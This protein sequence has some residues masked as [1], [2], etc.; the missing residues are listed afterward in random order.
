MN[1]MPL[2]MFLE[3][4]FYSWKHRP[5]LHSHFTFGYVAQVH[6]SKNCNGFSCSFF[7]SQIYT[8]FVSGTS[9]QFSVSPQIKIDTI[10]ACTF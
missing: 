8:Q 9:T 10:K 7:V 4:K 1:R 3:Y 6:A 2:K 5:S